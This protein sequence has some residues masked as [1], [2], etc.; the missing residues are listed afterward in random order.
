M[1]L[2]ILF[3]MRTASH[4]SYHET[5]LNH[6]VRRGHDVH[7]Q[8]DPYWNHKERIDDRAFR[9]WQ[10]AGHQVSVGTSRQRPIG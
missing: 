6:L 4:F 5:T 8:F 3:V 10:T 2:K 1:S 9:A 7:L